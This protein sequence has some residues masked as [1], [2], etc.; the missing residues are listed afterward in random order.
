ML[1]L[2]RTFRAMR[3]IWRSFLPRDALSKWAKKTQSIPTARLSTESVEER[4]IRSLETGGIT[5]GWGEGRK[6]LDNLR[7]DVGRN[8]QPCVNREMH[9]PQGSDWPSIPEAGGKPGPFRTQL[10]YPWEQVA[11]ASASK[12]M[13]RHR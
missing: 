7:T 12:G 11:R 4:A 8:S 13:V 3:A 9:L 1:A 5:W 6:L 2:F 10:N